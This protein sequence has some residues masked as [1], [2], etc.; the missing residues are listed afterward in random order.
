[1]GCLTVDE[2]VDRLGPGGGGVV[3]ADGRRCRG[4][5]P[6]FL[7]DGH[8]LAELVVEH[9]EVTVSLIEGDAELVRAGCREAHAG[10]VVRNAPGAVSQVLALLGL[11]EVEPELDVAIGDW[12]PV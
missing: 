9:P 7:W 1:M 2:L 11:Q 5:V 4:L 6:G 8:D 10:D 3:I 12:L